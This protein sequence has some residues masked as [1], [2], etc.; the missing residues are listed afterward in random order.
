MNNVLH[1]RS[2][3]AEFIENRI[4]E[5]RGVRSQRDIADIVGYK[6]PNM[7]TMIKQGDTKVALDRITGFAKALD[8]DQSYLFRLAMEQFYSKNT[9]ADLFGATQIGCSKNEGIILNV[10]REASD[11]T[12]PVLTPKVEE[13]LRHLFTD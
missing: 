4:D 12:D 3:I 13:K 11:N 5:L 7:I 9:I 10:I 2:R 6:S 8:V 1:E